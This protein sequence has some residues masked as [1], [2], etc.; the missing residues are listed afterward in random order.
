MELCIE[1]GCDLVREEA[2]KLRK[3]DRL[4][5]EIEEELRR[6]DY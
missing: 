3:E 5:R 2:E 6:E 4:D 1:P